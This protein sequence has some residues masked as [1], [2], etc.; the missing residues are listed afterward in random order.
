MTK[1]PV[2]EVTF[3]LDK[4]RTFVFDLNALIELEDLYESKEKAV[5][6]L[7]SGR[8]RDIRNWFWAGWLHEDKTLTVEEVG[9]I[10]SRTEPDTI[11]KLADEILKAATAE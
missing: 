4:T 10:F 9:R 2:T 8:L 7:R 1:S 5:T 11:V 3:D 6:A